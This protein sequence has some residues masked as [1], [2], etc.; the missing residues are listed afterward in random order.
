MSYVRYLLNV[1]AELNI[2]MHDTIMRDRTTDLLN[3]KCIISSSRV[4]IDHTTD[5]DAH[6]VVNY[7]TRAEGAVPFASY[8]GAFPNLNFF[9]FFIMIEQKRSNRLR[10]S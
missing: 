7:M 3:T 9:N 8:S 2:S 4:T 1:L 5:L 6:S 10:E